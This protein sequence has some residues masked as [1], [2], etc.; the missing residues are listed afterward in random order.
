MSPA[1][2]GDVSPSSLIALMSLLA[3]CGG[4]LYTWFREGRTR[5][6]QLADAKAMAEKVNAD[7][8]ALALKV[9]T[10]GLALAAKVNAESIA[11]A[12]KVNSDAAIMAAKVVDDAEKLAAKV[13]AAAETLA[14]KVAE[15]TSVST[16]AA[17]EAKTAYTEANTINAKIANLNS[18]LLIMTKHIEDE[19]RRRAENEGERKRLEKCA[20]DEATF[21]ERV[22]AAIDKKLLELNGNAPAA[23]RRHKTT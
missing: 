15:N 12:A 23:L 14:N 8:A 11:M 1:I 9:N 21:N 17:A 22:K 5:E 16:G 10:E 13:H 19:E 3:T 7:A 20:H 4:F 2:V 6:W 18:Q